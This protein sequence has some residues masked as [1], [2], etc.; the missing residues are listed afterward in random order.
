MLETNR[1]KVKGYAISDFYHGPLAQVSA[2]SLVI[3]LAARGQLLGDASDMMLRIQ[4]L[5]P[6]GVDILAITDD[7]GIADKWK[8]SIKIPT[9]QGMDSISPF[10]F[11]IT[12]QLIALKLTDVKEIDPDESKALNKVTITK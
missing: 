6:S 3:V 1:I 10:L 8:L 11:A 9:V 7:D 12:M 2:G 5:E 4:S